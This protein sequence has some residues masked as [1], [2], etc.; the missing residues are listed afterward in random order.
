MP[1][2]PII[3][4]MLCYDKQLLVNQLCSLYLNDD[5][6]DNIKSFLFMN[7]R[8][9]WIEQEAHRCKRVSLSE[10]K[11][12]LEHFRSMDDCQWS[13]IILFNKDP[14]QISDRDQHFNYFVEIGG[15]NC[16]QCGDFYHMNNVPTQTLYDPDRLSDPNRQYK[17]V[18]CHCAVDISDSDE[19]EEQDYD[20]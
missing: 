7:A 14:Y 20:F 4:P 1:T 18:L 9:W 10:A 3:F 11:N 12:C 8:E 13:H 5:V 16:E 17:N 2:R 15:S 6:R 19:E